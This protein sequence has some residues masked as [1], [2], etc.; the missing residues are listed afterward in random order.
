[1][2]TDCRRLIC[3]LLFSTSLAHVG[4]TLMAVAL[5]RVAGVILS[6]QD[7]L[8]RQWTEQQNALARSSRSA[9]GEQKQQAERF[10]GLLAASALGQSEVNL[11]AREWEPVR[12]MLRELSSSRARQGYSASETASFV[13]ALKLP[14]FAALREEAGN[15]AN[16]LA[17]DISASSYMLD[18]LG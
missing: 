1:R 14:L 4:E 8:V 6:H 3:C 10:T 16:A 5:S 7:S 12:D 18:R 9:P 13:F 15:D 2:H 11:D 17:D